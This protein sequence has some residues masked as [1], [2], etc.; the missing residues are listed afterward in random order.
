MKQLSNLIHSEL[1]PFVFRSFI[2]FFL[3]FFSISRISGQWTQIGQDLLGEGDYDQFGIG[4]S[5]SG[6]GTTIAAGSPQNSENG[7][8]KGH[9]RVFRNI[10]GAWVQQ[11]SDIEGEANAEALGKTVSL[12]F[13]GSVVAIGSYGNTINGTGSGLCK[14][15]RFQG[16]TW[17]QIG[18]T[19][20][21]EDELYYLG[22]SVSLSNDGNTLAV[23]VLQAPGGGI[24]R[25]VVRVFENIGNS[26]IQVG[27]DIMG[28]SDHD[29][30]G[31]II[32]LSDDGSTVA[33]SA[34]ENDAN[35]VDRGHVRVYKNVGGTWI[36]QGS[37]IDGEFDNGQSGEGVSLSSNG[38]ILAV[39]DWLNPGGGYYRGRVR[40]YKLIGGNWAQQG[41]DIL[42]EAD[43]DYF[44][45]SVSLSADGLRLA[46]GAE[47]NSGG[48]MYR[49]QTR[50]FQFVS[51]QWLQVGT[52][53]DGV[54]DFDVSGG[55]VSLSNDGSIVASAAPFAAAGGLYRG[56]VRVYQFLTIED[57]D[58]DGVA[59]A[60]D[61]CPGGDD[62][63]DNNGD[64]MPDCQYLPLYEDI[65]QEWR[66]GNN[67]VR[68]AHYSEDGTCHSLCVSYNAV[69]AHIDHGDYLG[70]CD[71]SS[72]NPEFF[73]YDMPFASED[74]QVLPNP[75]N[76]SFDLDL[77]EISEEE[78]K[79][80]IYDVAGKPVEYIQT[81]QNKISFGSAYDPG[82]YFINVQLK[83]SSYQ[84]IAL[85]L[86]N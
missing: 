11:G 86:S 54:E 21:G 42:G 64:G 74:I 63:I 72:C 77:G 53:I 18:Q 35:G 66:C 6:D 46:A 31:Y 71:N 41:S 32:E 10:G 9:V 38:T 14:V 15:F 45:G 47:G 2:F 27:S 7:Y 29:R 59:D 17:L 39:G 40:V 13:D 81:Q 8:N 78:I 22:F 49:G 28:E 34:I 82:M 19:M 36:Q 85:K 33:I 48:G 30:S 70:N 65:I 68:I 56:L 55:R 4:L 26:W 16:G 24:F 57:E 37:D 25:G 51:N 80:D 3:L 62:S 50:I 44:G 12:S 83:T 69:Q 60:E 1:T 58:C 61:L 43:E 67:K 23:S 52:S 75:S 76:H 20:L 79:I 84:L 5:I 73:Q